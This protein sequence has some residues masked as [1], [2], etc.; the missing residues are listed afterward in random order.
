[1]MRG[2]LHILHM[3]ELAFLAV[4]REEAVLQNALANLPHELVVKINIVLP[5]QLPA[6]RFPGLGQVVQVG[7]RIAGARRA[8]ASRVKRRIRAFV[9]AP[10]QLQVAA[11]GEDATPLRHLGRDDAVEHIHAPVDGFQNIERCTDSH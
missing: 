8:G 3:Q 5:E 11:R 7:A 10:A 9:N 4:E 6:E 2:V 1:M